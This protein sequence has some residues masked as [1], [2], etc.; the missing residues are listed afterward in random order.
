MAIGESDRM[1]GE[2]GSR[3]FIG[4]PGQQLELIKA[5]HKTKTPITVVLMNGRPL[6]LPWIAKN[7]P[8][9]VETWQL[10]TQCGNAIA[11]V[12]YGDVNPGGKLPVSFPQAVGQEPL[13][14]NHK[15]TGRPPMADDRFTSKYYDL[16][17]EPLFPFGFGLSYSKFEFSDL[18]VSAEKIKPSGYI[19]IRAKVKN[20]SKIKGDEVAQLYIRDM[21]ASLTRPVKELKG[22]ERIT[23]NPGEIKEVEF[24]LGP[25]HLGFYNRHMEYIVEPGKFKVWIGPDSQEGLETIFE[26]IE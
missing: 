8:S 12:L 4:L 15:N 26:I 5:I 20:A 14:Y 22:F 25:E 24:T 16:S 21:V 23:L 9:I 18:T 7:I 10:G 17:V 6:A 2:G 3:A 1:S 13:Y 11:D 19:T